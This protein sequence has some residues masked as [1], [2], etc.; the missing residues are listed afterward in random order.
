MGVVVVV[1]GV[2]VWVA[3]VIR[4]SIRGEGVVEVAVFVGGGV[5]WEGVDGE[6]ESL[7]DVLLKNILFDF[8]ERFQSF[9]KVVKMSKSIF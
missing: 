9:A 1:G 7:K 2:V 4:S 5:E 8:N 3:D 6:V